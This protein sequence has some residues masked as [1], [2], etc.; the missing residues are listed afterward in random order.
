MKPVMSCR[1]LSAWRYGLGGPGQRMIVIRQL[2]GASQEVGLM[3]N[4]LYVQV[5]RPGESG[6]CESLCW[7][8]GAGKS[9][10]ISFTQGIKH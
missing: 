10:K 2:D 6:E 9:S 7:R 3:Q 1:E 8:G 5:S 4:K